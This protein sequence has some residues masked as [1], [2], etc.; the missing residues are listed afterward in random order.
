[1]ASYWQSTKALDL[2]LWLLAAMRL[3]SATRYTITGILKVDYT[4]TLNPTLR[5][6][7]VPFPA[8]HLRHARL[9]IPSAAE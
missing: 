6:D 1:M 7:A 2:A 3:T 5:N 9:D 4:G 8:P